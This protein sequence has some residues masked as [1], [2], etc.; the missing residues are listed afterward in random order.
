MERAD[1]LGLPGY[2]YADAQDRLGPS[3]SEECLMMP[4][5]GGTAGRELGGIFFASDSLFCAWEGEE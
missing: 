3:T 1:Q 4:Y 2:G 5:E